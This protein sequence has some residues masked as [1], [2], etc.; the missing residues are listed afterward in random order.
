[1]MESGTVLSGMRIRVDLMACLGDIYGELAT[2]E[3][4]VTNEREQHVMERHHEAAEDFYNYVRACVE[5]PE[6]IFE[7]PNHK[8]TVWFVGAISENRLKLVIKRALSRDDS[9][10]KNSVLTAHIIGAKSLG[11]IL[12]NKKQIYRK[13]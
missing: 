12:R 7:D 11:K 13:E 9:K 8:D 1:M 10:R 2:D 3:V 4:I 6:Y 5:S